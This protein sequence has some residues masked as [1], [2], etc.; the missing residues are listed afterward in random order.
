MASRRQ[1][2]IK[3]ICS[4]GSRLPRPRSYPPE[5]LKAGRPRWRMPVR[6]SPACQGGASHGSLGVM[7]SLLRDIPGVSRPPYWWRSHGQLKA[8]LST[9]TI[10]TA[11]EPSNSRPVVC[12]I[13]ISI[14][15]FLCS[16]RCGAAI[17][18]KA[19][20]AE[21]VYPEFRDRLAPYPKSMRTPQ[22]R[23]PVRVCRP[24]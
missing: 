21:G 10:T 17:C 4:P 15:G 8:D 16:V 1:R 6:K 22:P 18:P 11:A 2:K 9:E 14:R 23:G 3:K 24:S 12:F 13:T 19:E 20:C 5:R 7:A